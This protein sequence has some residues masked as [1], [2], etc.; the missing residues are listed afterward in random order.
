[1]NHFSFRTKLTLAFIIIAMIEGILIGSFS[2]F[3]SKGIVVRNKKQEMCDTINRIDININV[4]V[5]GVMEML[6][7]AAEMQA[8]QEL[9]QAGN[10]AAADAA[11]LP[12]L[13]NVCQD[14]IR[15]SGESTTVSVI[16]TSQVLY[17]Y[18]QGAEVRLDAVS[19]EVLAAYYQAT[20]NRS[21][22]VWTG[23][24]PALSTDSSTDPTTGLA[25]DPAAR[26]QVVTVA[27]AVRS[28]QNQ[29]VLG[30]I[31]LELSPDMYNNLLMGN[32]GL[33]QYQYLFIA[34]GKG[35]IVA[36]NPNVDNGWQTEINER[37]EQGS[38]RFDLDWNGKTYFV[39][40]QYNGLTGWKSFSA[41]PYAGMFPQARELG[42]YI[43]FVVLV[44]T[45]GITAVIVVLVY[46]MVRPVKTLSKAMEQV[47]EGDFKV[48]VPNRKTDEVGELINSFNFM[49]DKIN[50]L[51]NEICQEKIAQ[52]NAELQAL[53]AQI[54][55]HF[56]YNTL[57]SVN[58]MLIDREEY[59]I[60]E[61]IISLGSLMRYSIEDDSSFVTIDREVEY[62][63]SYLKIQKNRL[64]NRLSYQARV[65][66][67]V[68]EEKIPKLIL[69][70]IVE[71][72]IAHG[73]EPRQQPG[74][75][76]IAIEDLGNEV[77]ISI[78]DDG[79]GMTSEQLAD[80]RTP[81]REPEKEGHTRIGIRNV[82]RR[83]RLHYGE[84]YSVQI[85][86]EYQK[87][88]TV[89]LRIPKEQTQV[90]MKPSEGGSGKS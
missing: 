71:N 81:S 39:C 45:L 82:E 72:A 24:M 43:F 35:D 63:L 49:V 8:V 51:V 13:K 28:P 22:V 70:P 53:Q 20:D 32:H 47:Q 38:R 3:H 67:T 62:V 89:K 69:Q 6:D 10:L 46:A 11:V 48:Q 37:F 79:I 57:D 4:K 58:W 16:N 68:R 19:P 80:L 64:E 15:S 61:I 18:S 30:I 76:V 14:L 90:V 88:T 52:K 86:S 1:M 55:P 7:D 40:G 41:I 65:D 84:Q 50:T 54:N 83:I 5:R 36:N 75:V 12:E 74:R 78:R 27:R 56:L 26:R 59:D 60:S 44:S 23:A 66:A 31:I 21:Q 85:E 77:A 25:G 42:Q 73:I 33:Y 29:T 17:T 2:Y 9:C 87:G 34:D